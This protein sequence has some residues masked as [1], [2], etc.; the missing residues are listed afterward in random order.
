LPYSHSS[1]NLS[2]KKRGLQKRE[3]EEEISRERE[4]EGKSNDWKKIGL[5]NE[6][7]PMGC[8]PVGNRQEKERKMF[9]KN[10]PYILDLRL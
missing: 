7:Q 9:S 8:H 6:K 10:K 1:R 2:L 4:G 3:R 5:S